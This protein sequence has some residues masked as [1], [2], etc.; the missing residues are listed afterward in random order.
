MH[1]SSLRRRLFLSGCS[2]ALAAP[3]LAACGKKMLR[4][5]AVVAP[6]AT[7]LALGD[8]ITFGQGAAPQSSYPAVLARLSGWNVVNAGVSGDV[9]AQAL[10][11]T[12][13]LLQEHRPALVLLG[14]G[15]N[16]FLR[17][18]PE[19]DTRA[20]I[21]SICQQ[22]LA[23]GAQVLLIAIPRP[24]LTAAST[25]SLTDH[26]LYAELAEELQ[27][28]LQRQGWAEVLSDERLRSDRIHANAQG[29]EQFARSLV[30]TA[31]AVGLLE[32]VR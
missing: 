18:L 21:R 30:G 19:A 32:G 9:S 12:P 7:V 26:T 14:I 22:A 3:W 11:R 1:N 6:G 4:A 23:A 20:N 28:P 10:Q 31:H 15:G 29:Y 24:A 5:R 16:D 2:A 25:G 13:A 27:V 8:S 17:R